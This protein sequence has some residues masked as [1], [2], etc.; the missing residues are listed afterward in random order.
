MVGRRGVEPRDTCLSDRPRRPAG[1][2]PA[3]GGGPDPQTVLAVPS[4]FKRAPATRQVHHPSAE[5]GGFD[6]HRL[7]TA[8]RFRNGACHPAGSLSVEEDGEI[9]SQGLLTPTRFPDGD[10]H[11]VISSPMAES[12][13][14]ESHG[15]T[16]ALVSSEARH[17][18]RFALHDYLVPFR[19]FEPRTSWVWA[20]R[21]YLVGL[22]R[23]GVT[24]EI[25]T[26]PA[27]L[28]RSRANR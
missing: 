14:F 6:P 19:G 17:P 25:R 10:H 27:T 20:R 12:G 2:R 26:R 16:R 9:E 21:L 1:S 28:A 5:S 24:D 4:R 11:P 15:V 18:G 8:T 22:E 23:H 7:A 13:E 3:D